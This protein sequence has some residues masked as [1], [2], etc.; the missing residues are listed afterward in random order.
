M[1]EAAINPL[2]ATL[3]PNQKTHYLN[4]LHAG[5]PGGLVLGGAVELSAS[6]AT[7]PLIAK[8]RWEIPMAF[9]LMPALYY[10]FVA[11]KEKFPISEARA[12]RR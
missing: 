7:T 6:W 3:Y 8:L 4:I 10:G 1:C 2:V 9:F 12:G 5:W 11:L